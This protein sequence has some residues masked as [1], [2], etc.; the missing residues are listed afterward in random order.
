LSIPRHL[1]ID[2]LNRHRFVLPQFLSILFSAI[3]KMRG[4]RAQARAP[5]EDISSVSLSV[6]MDSA[7]SPEDRDECTFQF[8][9]AS[10]FDEFTKI[11]PTQE[12]EHAPNK[13]TTHKKTTDV[14]WTIEM[15]EKLVA[16]VLGLKA[17]VKTNITV[18]K[19]Y[20]L[21]KAQ[22]LQDRDFSAC[23]DKTGQAFQK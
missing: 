6:S 16:A 9:E 5:Q 2:D 1:V 14:K 22:L 23:F 19:K 12:F 11:V 20:E 7:I 15:E 13:K 17:H 8:E 18:E 3:A 21:V 10:S 4:T